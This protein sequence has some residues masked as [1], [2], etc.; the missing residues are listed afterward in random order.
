MGDEVR[1]KAGWNGD[2]PTQGLVGHCKNFNI[3]SK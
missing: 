3:Y 1:E 2:P